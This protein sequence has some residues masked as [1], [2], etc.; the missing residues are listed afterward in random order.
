MDTPAVNKAIAAA[1]EAGGGTVVFPAGTY[2]S[3]SIHLKSH[4]SLFL[5]MARRFWVPTRRPMELT[6]M[7]PPSPTSHGKSTRITAIAIGI[8]V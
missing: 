2:L 7:I 4:V 8:T 1:A 5:P 3:Y 6:P